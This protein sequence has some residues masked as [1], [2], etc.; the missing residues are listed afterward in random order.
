MELRSTVYLFRRR[1]PLAFSLVA[2][3]V[4]AAYVWS[5]VRPATYTTSISFAVN[6]INKEPTPDY[7]F[8]GF[9]ALQAADLFAKTVV[10][11]MQTP[12]VLVEIYDRAGIDSSVTSLR[13]LTSRF[14]TKQYSAQN[15][16]VTYAV[17]TEEEGRRIAAALT[18]VIG[19]R[20]AAVNRT[21]SGEALF[22]VPAA[23]P[24]IVKAAPDPILVGLVALVVGVILA[25]FVVPL[26][27][28][29]GRVPPRS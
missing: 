21:A 7:Q 24:V 18:E 25:M 4:V 26:A 20:T 8:D 17:P 14:K 10:S 19:A 27:D 6:R 23:R 13:S 29:L 3:A 9:Y 12:S 5:Y 11:W 22:E 16:V 1:Q 15:I 28:Y 2:L